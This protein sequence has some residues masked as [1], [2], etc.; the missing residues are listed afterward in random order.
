MPKQ[1]AHPSHRN[2]RR[3]G[4][5]M[6]MVVA[7]LVLMA[8]IGTAYIATARYDRGSAAQ[9]AD[10]VQIALLVQSVLNLCK[11]SVAQD[12]FDGNGNYRPIPRDP[13]SE[14]DPNSTSILTRPI[15]N[16]VLPD[17]F[18]YY[19]TTSTLYDPKTNQRLNYWLADR[20]PDFGSTPANN[21][22]HYYWGRVSYPLTTESDAAGS[23]R[24]YFEDPTYYPDPSKAINPATN[25]LLLRFRFDTE[26]EP[27]S[28][29][30]NGVPMP[31]FFI[32]TGIS[33][34]A[35]PYPALAAD[36]DGDGIADSFLVRMPI[37]QINGLTYYYAVRIVDNTAAINLN[38]A[39]ADRAVNATGNLISDGQRIFP[40]SIN[41]INLIAGS[42]P[43]AEFDKIRSFR[44]QAP[45]PYN[46]NSGVQVQLASPRT[47]GDSPLNQSVIRGDFQFSNEHD[48]L[49]MQLGRRPENPGYIP[50]SSIPVW[51][52]YRAFPLS[53]MLA[54]S[55][56]FVLNY[57]YDLVAAEDVFASSQTLGGPW[58]D[59]TRAVRTKP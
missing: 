57:R 52:H 41:L 19:N 35:N 39:W 59:A 50:N 7:L 36:A 42:N 37:G 38:T 3:P 23:V 46:P 1:K 34:M 28:K 12:L 44:T 32:N 14:L 11:T 40:T 51:Q 25:P 43:N 45:S 17:T 18:F 56:H 5:I 22:A 49:W 4:S 58:L 21:T 9:N 29:L 53:D 13:T 47:D 20:T 54:L 33:G 30:V 26:L 24:G 15:P 6:I 48:A 16:N 27:T 2:H 55:A 8:L 10:N 31:A